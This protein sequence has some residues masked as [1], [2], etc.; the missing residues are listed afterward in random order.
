MKKI[1]WRLF[2]FIFLG[3]ISMISFANN[4][5]LNN[6]RLETIKT[7]MKL[8]NA[9][10]YADMAKLFT[11]DGIVDSPPVKSNIPSSKKMNA[12]QFYQM[13]NENKFFIKTKINDIF[14]GIK[15]P[16]MYAVHLTYKIVREKPPTP[17]S[18]IDIFEFQQNSAKIKLLTAIVNK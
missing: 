7:Y 9:G 13:A 16:N 17:R 4:N 12:V 2:L 1:H 3:M 14:V 5:N 6:D 18:A 10:R 11:N 8:L 15:K